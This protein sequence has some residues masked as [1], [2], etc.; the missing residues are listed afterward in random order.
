MTTWKLKDWVEYIIPKQMRAG[1]MP[2]LSIAVVE[3][4]KTIYTEGFGSRDKEKNLPSTPDTLHGIGSITKSFVAIAIMQL[5][6][7]GL[8][9]LNDPVSSLTPFRIG[10]EENPITVHHLLT[11]SLG[12][13][14][15][16]TSSVAFYKSV[17]YDTGIPFGSPDDFY[18]L[19]NGARKEVVDAPGR[20]FFYH[21]AAWRVLGHI[22]QLKSGK[23]FHRYIKENVLNPLGMKR[24]TLN[25][26]EFNKDLD[27]ITCYWKKPNGDI[28]PTGFPYP[29]PEDNPNFSFMAAAGGITSS[30]NEM[31]DYMKALIAKDSGVI[32][33]ESFEKMQTLYINRPSGYYGVHGYGYGLDITPDFHGYKMMSHG[34]SILVSTA[35]MS[36]V[37]ET[38][39]GV[40]VMGNSAKV[41]YEAINESILALLMGLDPE[42]ST[43]ELTVRGRLQALTGR[44]ETYMGIESVNIEYSAGMLYLVSEGPFE[45]TRIPLIPVDP[46]KGEPVFYSIVDSVKTPIVFEKNKDAINLFVERYCYHKV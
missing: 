7:K 8:I 3:E 9:D 45:K 41:A 37:P 10:L 38:E 34:G 44:Y 1:K 20:R 35:H 22:I 21:N 24:S 16:G 12:V 30:A 13:P 6:E 46:T 43:P 32:S 25:T 33:T 40:I 42:E 17:G 11:H 18:R 39:T 2:G 15:L 23:P 29:N 31:A 14:S 36:L 27:R 5:I 28:V 19:I 4:G 26:E